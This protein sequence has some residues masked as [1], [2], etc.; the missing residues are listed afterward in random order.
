MT[1]PARVTQ[2]ATAAVAVARR[3]VATVPFVG[4]LVGKGAQ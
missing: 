3:A 4:P 1:G 2:F